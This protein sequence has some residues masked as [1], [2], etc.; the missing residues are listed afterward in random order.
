MSSAKVRTLSRVLNYTATW[1]TGVL[2]VVT[3]ANHYL[4]T[5]DLVTLYFQNSPQEIVD[6]AVTVTNATTFT[7]PLT[8][9]H[10][11]Q[12]FGQ[13]TIKFYSTGM[14]GGQAAFTLPKN[15]YGARVIQSYVTGTGG[16][17]YTLELSLDAIHWVTAVATV[18][19]GITTGDTQSVTVDPLWAYGR[20]NPSVI[21]SATTLTVMISA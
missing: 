16:A 8:T 13:V 17:T 19:H 15:A 18:T 5:N 3:D 1:A 11:A 10:G 4:K 12:A 6:V 14:T 2:T 7:I 20:I 21:G 9:V